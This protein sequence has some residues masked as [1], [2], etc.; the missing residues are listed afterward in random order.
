[1]LFLLVVL[2]L[3]SHAAENVVV[4]DFASRDGEKD[5]TTESL[6]Y[7]FEEALSENCSYDVLERRKLDRLQAV[8]KNEKALQ[9]IGELTAG[10]STELRRLGVS[11]VVFGEVYDDVDSGEVIVTVTFQDFKGKKVLIR[12][13]PL[14]RGLLRDS[15]SRRNSMATLAGKICKSTKTTETQGKAGRVMA[16]DF[17]FDLE[18]CTLSDRSIL[19]NFQITNNGEDRKLFIV[20]NVT[21]G[22][23]SVVGET[24][25]PQ[26]TATIIYDDF[27]NEAAAVRAQVSNASA[28]ISTYSA[29]VGATLIS[30]RPAQASLRFDGLSSKA[31]TVTRLDVTCV[32]GETNEVFVATFKNLALVK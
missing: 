6:T 13:I 17:I 21:Y 22:Y 5:K 31:T 3:R 16:N 4:W 12:S 25:V 14:R 27:N 9:D 18:K 24:R 32:D 26:G 30:G 1:M 11:L 28:D 10:G 29:S 7:E 20:G 19:C 8:I 23:G 2:S 15:T